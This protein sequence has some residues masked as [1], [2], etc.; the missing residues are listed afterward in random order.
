MLSQDKIFHIFVSFFSFVVLILFGFLIF[1]LVLLAWPAFSFLGFSFFTSQTWNPAMNQFGALPFIYGT[2]ASSFISL[3][4]AT[5][6]SVGTALILVEFTPKKISHILSF[7]VEMLA[8]I[9]SVVYGLWGIFI[10]V[11]WVRNSAGPFLKKTLGFLPFFQGPIYGVGLLTAGLILAIMIIPTITS[12]CREVF[13]AIPLEQKEGALALGA[14]KYEMTKLAILKGSQQGI[15]SS[16]ILG[17]GRALGE[18]MAVTMV[19][20]N[21]ADIYLSVFAPAQS[22]ASLMANEYP[23]ASD[24]LHLSSLSAMGLCLLVVS[25]FTYS[26]ARWIIWRTRTK[27]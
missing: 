10:L 18:T 8:A 1:Q 25:F 4:I 2:L 24:S 20:G 19:I 16:A 27:F 5:P 11:P 13:K 6:I 14:T 17:L 12:L 22:I 23:E 26:I 9:P 7:L 3:I 21:R 15:L